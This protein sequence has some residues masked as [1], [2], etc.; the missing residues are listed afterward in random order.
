VISVGFR[1]AKAAFFDTERVMAAMDR[2]ERGA[3][4][5][6]GAFVRRTARQSI[7]KRN[8]ISLPGQPPSDHGGALKRFLFFSY[9]FSTRSVVIGPAA[10]PSRYS[11]RGPQVL[12]SGGTVTGTD[13]KN[14]TVRRVYK[15]RPYMMP[16][17]MKE[18]AAG[19]IP[20]QFRGSLRA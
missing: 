14:H 13:K 7:R 18:V 6:A 12:E 9:D 8:K 19:T 10:W 2:A 15:S 20:E 16:A 17:L 4:S 1:E 11:P 3:L 5:R